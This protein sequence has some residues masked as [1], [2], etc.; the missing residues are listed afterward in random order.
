MVFLRGFLFPIFSI[1]L[2]ALGILYIIAIIILPLVMYFKGQDLKDSEYYFLTV[3]YTLI[4]VC[5]LSGLIFWISK[6]D[7]LANKAVDAALIPFNHCVESFLDY[8]PFMKDVFTYSPSK[9]DS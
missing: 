2:I 7:S 9:D 1:A 6:E 5:I 4:C 8:Y 3:P